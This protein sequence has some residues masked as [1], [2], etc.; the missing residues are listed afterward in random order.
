MCVAVFV[1][2]IEITVLHLILLD[3]NLSAINKLK[4]NFNTD[5]TV[6]HEI[7]HGF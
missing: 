7:K 6:T 2:L 1:K 5:S 3:F 4:Y